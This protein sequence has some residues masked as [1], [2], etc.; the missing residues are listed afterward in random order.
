M[1]FTGEFIT[2]SKDWKSGKWLITFSCDQESALSQ[3]DK[4]REKPLDIKATRHRNKRSL[5]SNA[6]AWVLMQKIAEEIK[7]D[8]WAVYMDMLKQYSRA[9]THIIVKP[10][11]VEAVQEL[12]RTSV[13]LGEI[14]INGQ[15]GHQLQVYFGS[16]SF[17]SKE[18]S[19]FLEGIVSECKLLNIE[20][21]PPDELERMKTAWK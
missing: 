5:D 3:I 9:F 11:A 8:K 21:L 1:E 13:D 6:Y 12:Y 10:N 16:S 19:V 15:K 20:T 7:S 18:M 4:I 14:E 17:D 2:A